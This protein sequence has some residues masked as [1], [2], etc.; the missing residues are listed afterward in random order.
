MAK[1]LDGAKRM[2]LQLFVDSESCIKRGLH[3]VDL[4]TAKKYV[5]ILKEHIED[6]ALRG[7]SI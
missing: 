3:E 5:E 2:R 6:V 7:Y 4:E 1:E